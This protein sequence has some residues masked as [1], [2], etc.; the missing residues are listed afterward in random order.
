MG[1][2]GQQ[3]SSDEAKTY[4]QPNQSEKERR[5]RLRISPNQEGA[6]HGV[7]SH[8]TQKGQKR[9]SNNCSEVRNCL[10]KQVKYQGKAFGNR[11]DSLSEKEGQKGHCFIAQDSSSTH[12]D[13]S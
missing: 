1:S 13:G 3:I 11:I 2:H 10:R 12:L 5:S 4:T 8:G 9:H 6:S 7:A